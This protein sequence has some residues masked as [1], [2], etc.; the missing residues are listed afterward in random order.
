M[1]TSK[2][3]ETSDPSPR[4]TFKSLAAARFYVGEAAIV[5]SL[6]ASMRY[7]VWRITSTINMASPVH[8]ALSC[9]L[10]AAEI[11]GFVSVALFYF[12]VRRP[13]KAVP[14][15][16]P[17]SEDDLPTVDVFVAIYDEP[18]DILYRTLVGCSAIDYP[19]DKINVYVLDDG[20][21]ESIRSLA[22]RFG[23]R[24][25][26][27]PDRT[28]AKAGN[29]NNAL[30]HSTGD[31]VLMLDTDHIPV[32]SILKETVGYFMDKGVA[33]VQMP[34]HFYNPDIFQHNLNLDKE[35]V[36]E[37]DL[38]FQ[39]IQPGRQASNSVMFAGSST[40]LRRKALAS[41]GGIQTACAIED[42]HTSM[43]LQAAGWQGIYHNK[44]L[45]GALS[46][47]SY[48]GYLTQRQRWTRGGVQ[49]FVLDNPLLRAGLNFTQRL[50]Y[51]SSMLY[52]FH[53]WARM[54]YMLSPLAFLLW[55][56]D[57]IVCNTWTLMTY[58]LP[59]YVFAHLAV[60]VISREFRNPFWSDV[61]EVAAAFSL[62][63]TAFATLLQPDKLIF[64]VTPKGENS[65]RPH[66]VPW[67]YVIPHATVMVL[68]LA[69]I[70]LATKRLVTEGLQFDN[71]TLSCAWAVFNV[72]LLGCAIEGTRERPHL[73]RGHRLP[74]LI[75]CQLRFHG[76]S[77]AGMATSVSES[78]CLVELE[79]DDHMPPIV[80]VTL[81]GDGSE[82][83]QLE[84]EVVHQEHHDQGCRV[85]VRFTDL[86][87]ET[88]QSLL[89]QMF[90][91]PESWSEHKR[92]HVSSW[93]ALW[94]IGTSI[95]HPRLRKPQ[96]ARRARA[97]IPV[98][99]EGRVIVGAQRPFEVRVEE[100][101]FS[102]ARVTLPRST[103][104]PE[105]FVLKFEAADREVALDCRRVRA[106]NRPGPRAEYGVKFVPP[107]HL[108]PAILEDLEGSVDAR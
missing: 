11:Y 56:Y 54:I 77:F 2:T 64:N 20:P 103:R 72:V 102:G 16:L 51:F 60:L 100:L 76:R 35:L 44:I 33:F 21:R 94:H 38:F 47:E 39:V 87:P 67:T 84:G 34:H 52:F 90:S 91:L 97:R 58:F 23:C 98:D 73:R 5:L 6:L 81:Q 46:P 83:T 50:C 1:L 28:H 92:P 18:T 105:E 69:G 93:T 42:T 55:R 12:Q 101:S 104:M 108:D 63:W 25:L 61:Y 62:A 70:V 45:S 107:A 3:M 71:Y 29:T 41:V 8:T 53:G 68:L 95:L 30:K 14:L 96:R 57:P 85:G 89:R 82:P 4:N 9:L 17:E 26:T 65:K 15:P 10:M 49:L 27:R 106:G 19:K 79:H 80:H 22:E 37:Q 31:L 86:T 66:Q 43:R 36:H 74:R 40:I 75:P 32:K 88:R 59:H 7:L 48:K 78:G 13:V 24:Y 99:L